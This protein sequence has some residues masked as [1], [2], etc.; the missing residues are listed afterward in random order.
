M[1]SALGV[2][3]R[4][5]A[6]LDV[7]ELCWAVCA[8]TI[9]VIAKTAEAANAA[10]IEDCMELSSRNELLL[11]SKEIGSVPKCWLLSPMWA[12]TGKHKH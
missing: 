4:L 7:S 8:D 11:N 10:M 12:L 5:A 1:P 3:E 2:L 9:E 6:A